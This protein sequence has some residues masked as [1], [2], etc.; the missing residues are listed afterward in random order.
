MVTL[1]GVLVLMLELVEEVDVKREEEG[2]VVVVFGT[3]SDATVEGG[4]VGGGAGAG[5]EEAAA[6]RSWCHHGGR[7][8]GRQILGLHQVENES[9]GLEEGN[10]FTVQ[11]YIKGVPCVGSPLE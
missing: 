4:G 9:M 7:H 8:P 6:S 10:V 11:G 2:R 1:R 5:V 3:G